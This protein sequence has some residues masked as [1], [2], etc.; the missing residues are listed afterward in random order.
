M[1]RILILAMMLLGSEDAFSWGPISHYWLNKGISPSDEVL[2]NNG[3]NPDLFWMGSDDRIPSWLRLY[4]KEWG[5]RGHCPLPIAATGPEDPRGIY[6][7]SDDK[8]NFAY[9][10]K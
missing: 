6:D 1:K 10:M 8:E 9:I 2:C 5:N 3:M 4:G 7:F